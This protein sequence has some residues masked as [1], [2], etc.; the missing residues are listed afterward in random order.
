[1][2]NNKIFL[3]IKGFAIYYI[4]F[5]LIIFAFPKFYNGQFQIYNFSGYLPLNSISPFTH[6]WSFFGRSY[7]YNLFLGII[8]FLTAILILF[9]RTRLIGL[10]IAFGLFLNI[11]IIDIEF[12]VVD[13]LTHVIIEFIL[14]TLL[15]FPYI[16]DLK[17]FFW[18]MK[19]RFT[20]NESNL[21]NF[22]SIYFPLIFITFLSIALLFESKYFIKEQNKNIAKFEINDIKISNISL[23]ISKGEFTPKPM[24]FLEFGNTFILSINNKTLWGTY[25]LNDNKIELVFDKSFGNL[26]K[27]EG[28]INKNKTFIKGLT[29]NKEEIF[30][31]LKKDYSKLYKK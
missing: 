14:V 7:N 31:D 30:I 13:A 8:E 11:L 2:K 4:A 6:A 18:N 17:K 5:I 3:F 23:K 12:E 15:L 29:N 28:I 22:T 1:M 19:G 24:L 21:S 10:L 26:K 16:K 20:N 25:Q 27:I 9:N